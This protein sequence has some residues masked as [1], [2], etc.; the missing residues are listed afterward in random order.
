M[1]SVRRQSNLAMCFLHSFDFRGDHIAILDAQ[2]VNDMNDQRET[3]GFENTSLGAT[4]TAYHNDYIDVIAYAMRSS[5]SNSYSHVCSHLS[6][7]LFD[8][9]LDRRLFI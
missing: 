4:Q 6:A 5:N 8:L 7:D 2:T 1:N 9:L 3:G